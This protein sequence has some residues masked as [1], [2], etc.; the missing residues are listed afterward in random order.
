MLRRA[1]WMDVSD[2]L[3]EALFSYLG[4]ENLEERWLGMDHL[5]P[6]VLEYLR[7]NLKGEA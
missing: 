4:W 5:D 3:E 2:E 1:G 6:V 7:E